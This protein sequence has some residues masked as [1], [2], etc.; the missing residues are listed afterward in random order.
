MKV[1]GEAAY[2]LSLPKELALNPKH[3][4]N[5]WEIMKFVKCFRNVC[6]KQRTGKQYRE[7]AGVG[8]AQLPTAYYIPELARKEIP[9]CRS[10]RQIVPVSRNYWAGTRVAAN[11][12]RFCLRFT[13]NVRKFEKCSHFQILFINLKNVLV[14]KTF[15][16]I[17]K[18]SCSLKK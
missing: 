12:W 5:S 2:F 9:I 17:Q 4:L 14:S 11:S 13:E 3:P 10:L 15:N 6:E 16:K 1:S 18:C 7:R 8:P